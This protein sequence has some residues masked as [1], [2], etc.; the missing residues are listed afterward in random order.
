MIKLIS[1]LIEKFEPHQIIV[2]M[3]LA[4]TGLAIYVLLVKLPGQ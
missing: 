2:L 3:S 4:I 1:K